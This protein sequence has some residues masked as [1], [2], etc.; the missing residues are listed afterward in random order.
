MQFREMM[1]KAGITEKIV[2][3]D[4]DKGRTRSSKSFHSLRHGFISQ[5]AD[6]GVG[7]D[8][9]KR[10]AGHSDDRVHE[11]Y[12]HHGIAPLKEAINR[13]PTLLAHAAQA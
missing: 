6:K 3:A 4:G 12:A 1:Q 7:A 10:L 11:R 5:L 8:L 9:R 2:Q 13:L